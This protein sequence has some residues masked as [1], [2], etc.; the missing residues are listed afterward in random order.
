MYENDLKSGVGVFQSSDKS[1]YFKGDFVKGKKHGNGFEK[2]RIAEYDGDF[3]LGAK[4]GHCNSYKL[5]DGDFYTGEFL[6]NH[7]Y[8][9]G[10][11]TWDNGDIY[12]G[13]WL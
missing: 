5:S 2:T 6:D 1:L 13:N 9:L 12:H 11:Y 8:G 10:V 3:V 7:F 4:E